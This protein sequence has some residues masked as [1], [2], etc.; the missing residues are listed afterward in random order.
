MLGYGKRDVERVVFV[1]GRMSDVFVE[2]ARAAGRVALL[3]ASVVLLSAT[4]S[5]SVVSPDAARLRLLFIGAILLVVSLMVA[6]ETL[7]AVAVI[8]FGISTATTSFVVDLGG[9]AFYLTDIVVLVL[10]ARALLPRPRA[11]ATRARAAL[12]GLPLLLFVLWCGV[13]A[14]ASLRGLLNGTSLA[15]VVRRETALFYFPLLFFSFSRLLRERDLDPRK[16]WRNLAY[17][18]LGFVTWML[19]MRVLNHPFETTTSHLGIVLTSSGQEVHRDF[20]FA[21]A[22]A[23]YP[24]LGLVGF[25]GMAWNARPR[26]TWVILAF[27]GA[28]ATLMSLGRGL[29]FSMCL[30]AAAIL[31]CKSQGFGTARVRSAVQIAVGVVVAA[32]ALFIASPPLGTAIAQRSLP[33]IEAQSAAARSTAEYRAKA[34]SA[35]FAVA[36]THP[37]GLGVLDEKRLEAQNIDPNYLVHSGVTYLLVDGGWAAAAITL[38]LALALIARSFT[39]PA[40]PRWMHPAFV[41]V[42]TLLLAFSV[43]AAGLAGDSW[44]IGPAALAIALRFTLGTMPEAAADP[45]SRVHLGVDDAGRS[46]DTRSSHSG[47]VASRS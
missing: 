22:F 24:I 4:A 18:V 9:M 6:P 12:A 28:V 27:V 38:F 40:S 37:N 42:M 2:R 44:V 31:L 8:C 5:Y 46:A 35:G 36:R 16:L 7:I 19:L 39:T 25:A 29:I 14:A 11:P 3:W 32:V 17:A 13:L 23:L 41:G 33:G 1:N 10:L 43:T 21:S 20:G 45:T 47:R 15:A 26:A 30:G 34:L